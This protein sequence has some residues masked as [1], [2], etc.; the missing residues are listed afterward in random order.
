MIES[1][2][3]SSLGEMAA[4]IAHE[5][6]NPLAIIQ[7]SA[8]LVNAAL[9]RGGIEPEKLAR[10]MERISAT[11]NRIAKIITG[12]KSFAR[13]GS[14]DPFVP[15]SLKTIVG[16][17]L[18]LCQSRYR[19]NGVELHLDLPEEDLL[20]AARPVQLAQLLV[21][22]LNNAFDAVDG[23]SDKQVCIAVKIEGQEVCLRVLDNG[24]GVPAELRDKILQPFF[25]TKAPGKGTG[26]GLSL[27][28]AIVEG[29][30]GRLS[31]TTM[32]GLTCFEAALP[33]LPKA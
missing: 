1:A 28:R 2:R 30:G 18:E 17:A 29:H 8:D 31:I 4:G 16:E 9:E 12:L 24:P 3:L 25:T 6:N 27:S 14:R 20:V 21:N 22:L 15:A 32:G 10:S 26:L 19:H 33:L 13:D 7:G 5:I 23:Q 11:V